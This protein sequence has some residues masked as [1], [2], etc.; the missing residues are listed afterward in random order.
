MSNDAGYTQAL[1]TSCVQALINHLGRVP[2]ERE[3]DLLATAITRHLHER[4]QADGQSD[5]IML[6]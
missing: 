3:R 4:R 1:V 6:P 2:N 5:S